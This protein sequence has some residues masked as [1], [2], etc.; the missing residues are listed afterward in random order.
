[1][2]AVNPDTGEISYFIDKCLPFGSSIS[3]SHFQ[4]FSNALAHIWKFL[5]KINSPSIYFPAVV[6]YLDDFLFVERSE[7]ICN[8]LL[9]GFLDMCKILS[10]PVA[11]DKTEWTSTRMVFLGILLDGEAKVLVIPV[12]KKNRTLN[13]LR[14]FRHKKKATVKQFQSL[15][16]LL[17]FLNKAIFP[18]RAFTRRMY[19]KFVG[20]VSDSTNKVLKPHH[21]INLDGEFRSDCLVWE[22]FLTVQEK[23]VCRPFVDLTQCL[24]ATKLNFFT[25]AAKH[26]ALGFGAIFDQ[27]WMFGQW[28]DEFIKNCDPSI[29]Y[30]ELFSLVI[31][32]FAWS[33]KLRNSRVVVFCDNQTVM[34]VMNQTASS[35]KNCMVLVRM[36]T[37]CSLEYNMRIFAQWVRGTQNSLSDALSRMKFKRFWMLL[38][39]ERRDVNPNPTPLPVELWPP[40][41]IWLPLFISIQKCSVPSADCVI[42]FNELNL[43]FP[44]ARRNLL[45]K[46][47]EEVCRLQHHRQYPQPK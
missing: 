8:Q 16:G 14:N 22:Q 39:Q 1:M 7:K 38:E 42:F 33:E 13:L 35:C 6:N 3:C 31:A 47:P 45:E 12:E 36:L 18:G 28:G 27:D 25:D 11:V 41:K 15:A 37:L 10:V 46:D 20:L 24:Q 21:H 19:S 34:S 44:Q 26:G 32:V 5:Q 30:L 40:H 29:E 17:N 23:L 9:T 43:I 2:K 4:R